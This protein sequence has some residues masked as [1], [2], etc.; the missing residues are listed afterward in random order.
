MKELKKVP[1]NPIWKCDEIGIYDVKEIRS[2]YPN[3]IG[4]SCKLMLSKMRGLL[5]LIG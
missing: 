1:M 4:V 2:T 5:S 3:G